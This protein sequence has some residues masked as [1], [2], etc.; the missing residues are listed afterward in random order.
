MK[1]ADLREALVEG[2]DFKSFSLKDVKVDIE[3]AVYIAR[4]F[5]AVING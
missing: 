4:A 1:G 5:G 2:L 3:Q